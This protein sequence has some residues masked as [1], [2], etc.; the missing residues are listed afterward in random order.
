[1]EPI[2]RNN[3]TIVIS[4]QCH[5]RK[6]IYLSILQHVLIMYVVNMYHGQPWQVVLLQSGKSCQQS[7]RL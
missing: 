6:H 5:I 3:V 1:M 7:F 2:I 4:A